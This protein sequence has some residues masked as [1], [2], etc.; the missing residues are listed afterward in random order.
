M[1][2]G[3]GFYG[4]VANLAVIVNVFL[5]VGT[6]TILGA[7]LTLPG[8]A[9]IVLT[10]GMAVDSNVLIYERIREEFK[11]G[12]SAI[13]SIDLG[14]RRA[15]GTILDANI[16]TLIAAIVLFQLGTGPIRGFAVTHAIGIVTTVFTAFTFT[17]LV[18]AYWVRRR[19]P[20]T[21]NL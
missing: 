11:T 6:L 4:L 14:F 16:T 13:Q 2:A 18:L 3:Y 8:I 19:R 9:G 21:V 7:T 20:T 12:R 5:V 15:L 1:F 17:R 10:I